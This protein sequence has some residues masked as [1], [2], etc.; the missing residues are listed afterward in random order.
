MATWSDHGGHL[1]HGD[2]GQ[3]ERGARGIIFLKKLFTK[4]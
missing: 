4:R 2:G 3:Q 1:E